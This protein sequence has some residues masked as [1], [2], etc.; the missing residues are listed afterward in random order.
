MSDITPSAGIDGDF[1]LFTE[2]YT[3]VLSQEDQSR[4]QLPTPHLDPHASIM[5][6]GI[7]EFELQKR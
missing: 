3:F 5:K 7:R 1:R 4:L 2:E 6:L